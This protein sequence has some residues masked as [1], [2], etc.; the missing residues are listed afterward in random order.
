MS[1][2]EGHAAEREYGGCYVFRL[3][4]STGNLEPV[5][6]DFVR[7]NGLAFSPDESRLYVV[8]SGGSH[9]L[10]GDPHFIRMFSV[11]KDGRLSGGAVFAEISPG[12]PDGIRLDVQGNVWT[13]AGDGVQ[14]FSSDGALLGK[15]LVPEPV[16]NLTFGGPKRNRIFITATTSLYAVYVATNG[17]QRP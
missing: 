11:E 15:I 10:A 17:I 5:C 14:C 1:D 3:E 13:T 9:D 16:A 8:D 2:Y 4:L 7:P 12:V 6:K